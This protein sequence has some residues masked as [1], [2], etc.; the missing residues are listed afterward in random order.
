MMMLLM[1]VGVFAAAATYSVTLD[2]KND[3]NADIKS[4]YY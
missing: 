1:P 3:G 2:V 4:G